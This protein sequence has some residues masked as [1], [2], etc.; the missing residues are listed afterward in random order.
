[1]LCRQAPD[2]VCHIS[3]EPQP[4]FHKNFDLMRTYLRRYLD[5]GLQLYILSDSAK[6][7]ERLHDIFEE[8]GDHFP[9][10][11]IRPTLHE[12]FIDRTR[13]C[14]FLTDHQIFDRFHRYSLRGLTVHTP[15]R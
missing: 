14:C 8:K 10:T 5:E 3:I 9:F 2:A 4:L 12:G 1:M 6:Q 7:Q 11:A 15:V 13:R